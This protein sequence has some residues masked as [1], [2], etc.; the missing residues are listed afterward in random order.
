[1]KSA[2]IKNGYA[3]QRWK[4]ALPSLQNSQQSQIFN[5]YRNKIQDNHEIATSNVIAQY[6]QGN[7]S[8]QSVVAMLNSGKKEFGKSDAEI[9]L[10][11][12]NADMKAEYNAALGYV[13]AEANT[14]DAIKAIDEAIDK[15]GKWDKFPNQDT[16]S[17]QALRNN[18]QAAIARRNQESVVRAEQFESDVTNA[19]LQGNLAIEDKNIQDLIIS[20]P[21]ISSAT[22]RTLSSMY[23]Q[24]IKGMGKS[25]SDEEKLAAYVEIDQEQDPKKK[26]ALLAKYANALGFATTKSLYDDMTKPT[27]ANDTVRPELLKTIDKVASFRLDNM[28]LNPEWSKLSAAE[29]EAA[30]AKAGLDITRLKARVIERDRE[31]IAKGATEQQRIDAAETIMAPVKEEAAKEIV[32]KSWYRRTIGMRWGELYDLIAGEEETEPTKSEFLIRIS[33]LKMAGKMED[34][35]KYYDKWYKQLWP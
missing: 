22:K 29:T 27:T 10:L 18:A 8:R 19:L 3:K 7:G 28:K 35:Q 21:D 34:A 11:L 24:T 25:Y 33:D 30:L 16:G 1:M 12:S 13:Q 17:L 26:K 31:L 20:N 2:E 14:E 15:G 23:S 4:A 32:K 6:I 9:E 5:A